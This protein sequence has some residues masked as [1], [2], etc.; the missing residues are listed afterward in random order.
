[1]KSQPTP[2]E[3]Y[4]R[5]AILGSVFVLLLA[6]AEYLA[7]I[8]FK[9]NAPDFSDENVL[10]NNLFV[11]FLIN[12]NIIILSYLIFLIIKNVTKLILDRKKNILGSRLRMKLVLAFVSLSAV[13]TIILFLIAKG[14]ISYFTD[15]YS[16]VIDLYRPIDSSYTL[17]LVSV[18][19]LVVFLSIWIGLRIAQ[20]I[21]EPIKML[22]R[23]TTQVAKGNLTFKIP[24]IGDDEIGTLITSFNIMT[25]NLREANEELAAKQ[26]ME[27]WQEVAKRIAHEIK[28]PLTPIQLCAQRLQKKFQ[29]KLATNQAADAVVGESSLSDSELQV[30]LDCS[31]TIVEQVQTLRTLVNEFSRF[32]RMPKMLIE[33]IQ[34]NDIISGLQ[35]LYCQSHSNI[36]FDLELDERLPILNVDKEQLNRVFVNLIDNAIAAI[37]GYWETLEAETTEIPRVI[38][39]TSYNNELGIVL[40]T[41]ADNGLGISDKDKEKV[42]EP[43]IT[44]K[45]GGTGLGL[46]IVSS[47][48]LNHDGF[49][50]IKNVDSHGTAFVVELP[51]RDTKTSPANH[52]NRAN[53]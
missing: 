48:I 25:N 22:A 29:A 51:V 23:G 14:F 7:E 43:Y 11:F 45:K 40:I 27:A 28:N 52:L 18:T 10:M 41:V 35:K 8:F 1:M 49:V 39:K 46:A 4:R 17:M 5:L 37:N 12:L 36:V 16:D 2:Q 34:L 42:F 24:E 32:A 33:P 47:I 30:I 15:S 13:P 6:A 21:S 9:G 44:N 26:R 20:N 31:Q 3:I 53:S 38:L 19:L 50:R